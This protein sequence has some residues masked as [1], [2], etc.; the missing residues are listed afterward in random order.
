MPAHSQSELSKENSFF[1]VL[2]LGGALD[3][4]RIPAVKTGTESKHQMRTRDTTIRRPRVKAVLFMPGDQKREQRCTPGFEGVTS[5][6]YGY[7]TEVG[8]GTSKTQR[9]HGITLEIHPG[10]EPLCSRKDFL[11]EAVLIGYNGTNMPYIMLYN[12]IMNFLNRLYYSDRKLALLR[13]ACVRTAAQTIAYLILDTPGCKDNIKINM[14]LNR[15]AQRF[16]VSGGFLNQ[17]EVRKI[18]SAPKMSNTSVVAWRAFKDELIHCFVFVHS[19]KQP[20]QL[21]SRFVVDLARR[22]P[23]YAKQRFLDYLND[24]FGCTSDQT[25]DSSMNFVVCEEKC[26]A[27]DFGVQL[28]TEKKSGR[29]AKS[30]VLVQVKRIS[31][32][33]DSSVRNIATSSVPP[34]GPKRFSVSKTSTEA[35]LV[36]P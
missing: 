3:R 21:E 35:S 13:A 34:K 17:P 16:G 14:A 1:V 24:R 5:I 6:P 32:N 9:Q 33:L 28:M 31:A 4:E 2:E 18:R 22:L 27:S 25:F 23:I 10:P 8:H 19:Y 26:I 12:Q 11:D 20:G 15:L 30:G 36:A 7:S 29:S